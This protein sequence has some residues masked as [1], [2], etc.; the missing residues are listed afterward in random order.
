MKLLAEKLTELGVD[1]MIPF[2]SHHTS[3]PDKSFGNL[4]LPV[5][6]A[7]KQS[8]GNKMMTIQDTLSIEE[9]YNLDAYDGKY[10]C[11]MDGDRAG[12]DTLPSG[13]YLVVIGPEGGFS[14]E[15]L[16]QFAAHGFQK[17]RLN[18]RILRAETA[19]IVAASKF[20]T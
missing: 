5:I 4:Q 8:G 10:Y 11:Q 7:L 14:T 19:A 6:S 12:F 3:F 16:Q 20:L 18:K 17:I 1:E 13:R 2:V 9:I 15:E